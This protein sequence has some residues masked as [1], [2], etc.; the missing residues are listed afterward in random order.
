MPQA[1]REFQAAASTSLSVPRDDICWFVQFPH[2]PCAGGPLSHSASIASDECCMSLT[3]IGEALALEAGFL[4]ETHQALVDDAAT[5]AHCAA[6]A[7]AAAATSSEDEQLTGGLPP[8][9]PRPSAEASSQKT[10]RCGVNETCTLSDVIEGVFASLI[11]GYRRKLRRHAWR[12]ICCKALRKALS[13]LASVQTVP[14]PHDPADAAVR[15]CSGGSGSLGDGEAGGQAPDGGCHPGGALGNSATSCADS[16]DPVG[17]CFDDERRDVCGLLAA[18]A[19]CLWSE[20]Q[21]DAR[22]TSVR[23]RVASCSLL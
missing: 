23:S 19:H 7:D 13:S 11:R 14:L 12:A 5:P 2:L 10:F 1:V 18:L 15:C 4:L 6:A 21:A 17:S 20:L 3:A 9:P 22:S 16:P 8:E